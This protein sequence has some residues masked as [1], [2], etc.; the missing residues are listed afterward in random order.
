M[1]EEEL[2]DVELRAG[3]AAAAEGAF[4]R[5]YEILD[6]LGDGGHKSTAAANLAGALCA[7]GRFDEAEE[8]A[9]IA[10]AVAAEDDVASQA[11]GRSVQ[12]MV[13][14]ARGEH[15]EAERLARERVEYSPRRRP[16]TSRAMRGWISPMSSG[17]P[18]R[19]P[20]PLQ[21]PASARPVRAERERAVERRGPSLH[22]GAGRHVGCGYEGW[23]RLGFET[24]FVEV[25]RS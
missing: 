21:P 19:K 1:L 23:S 22:R 18:V 16:R 6:A 14:A 9:S 5:N 12:A 15:P 7:L 3:D 2:G 25:V 20:R 24:Q 17:W 4:R 13:L 11:I 10:R 8:Y